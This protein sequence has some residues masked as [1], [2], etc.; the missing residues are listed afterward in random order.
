MT[1]R[2]LALLA[3]A[4]LGAWLGVRLYREATAFNFRGKT[5]L[6]TGGSRGLGL[7]FWPVEVLRPICST[8]DAV[9]RRVWTSM[10]PRRR[11]AVRTSAA[12]G[13]V[14]QVAGR[15]H[16]AA[17]AGQVVVGRRSSPA[18]RGRRSRRGPGRRTSCRAS[19][20]PAPA[21]ASPPVTSTVLPRKLNAVASR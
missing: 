19:M 17:A 3:G 13:R 5:V 14:G 18:R 1:G 9:C 8:A 4:R 16:G 7:V 12:S 21:P 11:S 2:N 6:V 10:P 15:Q 20:T